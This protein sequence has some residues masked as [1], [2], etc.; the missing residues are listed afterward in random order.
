MSDKSASNSMCRRVIIFFK[1]I[2][3]GTLNTLSSTMCCFWLHQ[4]NKLNSND[5]FTLLLLLSLLLLALLLLL[6]KAEYLMRQSFHFSCGILKEYIQPYHVHLSKLLYWISIEIFGGINFF[7]AF[8]A[9]IRIHTYLL[10]PRP[11]T[12]TFFF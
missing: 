9:F 6:I 1:F 5:T 10:L 11:L 12:S 7:M 4:P 3:I 2:I 8:V